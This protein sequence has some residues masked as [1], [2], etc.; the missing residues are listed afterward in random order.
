MEFGKARAM[1]DRD[2]GRLRQ[3]RAQELVEL[4]LRLV[5]QRRSAFIQEQPIRLVQERACKRETLLLTPGKG[6]RP[7]LLAREIIRELR[8]PNSCERFAYFVVGNP[9]IRRG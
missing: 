1:P 3:A 7:I 6:L 2:H 8:E 5:R 9:V 4:A